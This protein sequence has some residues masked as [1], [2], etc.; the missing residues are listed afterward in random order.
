MVF[1]DGKYRFNLT[2]PYGVGTNE[3]HHIYLRLMNDE[4]DG[5]SKETKTFTKA[6]IITKK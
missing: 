6:N 3:E 2:L 4:G 5:L 1:K